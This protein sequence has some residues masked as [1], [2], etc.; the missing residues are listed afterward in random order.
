MLNVIK[1]HWL[2]LCVSFSTVL[3]GLVAEAGA[4]AQYD[5]TPVQTSI[6]DEITGNLTPILAIF[7]GILALVVG[8]K[9]IK[10]FSH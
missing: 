4:T 1:R 6:T 8:M 3:M 5:L 10:R 2:A 7:G 9:L